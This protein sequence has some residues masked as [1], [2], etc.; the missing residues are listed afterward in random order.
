LKQRQ[1]FLWSASLMANPGESLGRIHVVRLLIQ[2]GFR[3]LD[4]LQ[5][6]G[7]GSDLVK[8]KVRR[9]P[10]ILFCVPCYLYW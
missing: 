7:E 9:M 6:M 4:G 1:R 2:D 10:A 3:G 5:N 8:S